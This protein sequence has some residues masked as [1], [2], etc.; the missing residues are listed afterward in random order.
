MALLD[1]LASTLPVDANAQ[2]GFT[3]GAQDYMTRRRAGLENQRLNREENFRKMEMNRAAPAYDINAFGDRIDTGLAT[4]PT[5][6]EEF[7]FTPIPGAGDMQPRL[8]PPD[9]TFNTGDTPTAGL[10]TSKTV[11]VPADQKGDASQNQIPMPEFVAPDLS[12]LFPQGT[13]QQTDTSDEDKVDL[14]VNGLPWKIIDKNGGKIVVHNGVEYNIKDVAGDGSSFQLVDT[15][16]RPNFALTD[17][18]TKGRAKGI[19]N[20]ELV[21]EDS[22]A[23]TQAGA[24]S[25]R[26]K[27]VNNAVTAIDNGRFRNLQSEMTVEQARL[28]GVP[29]GKALSLLAIE[30]NFGGVD[31]TKGP[32]KGALQ[33]EA[34]A[35]TDVKQFYAGKIPKGVDPAEWAKL[36]QAA[37]NLPKNFSQL[38]DNRDQITAGLLYFKLIGYKGVAPQFQAAAY[39]DGYGKFIGINSLQDVKKFAKNHDFKSVNTY[40]M[41]FLNLEDYL[42]K[43][44]NYFYPASGN[45]PP[46]PT[47]GP[48]PGTSTTTSTAN[49][50]SNTAVVDN[51]G[52]SMGVNPQGVTDSGGGLK[53]DGGGSTDKILKKPEDA[54]KLITKL[55]KNP[56]QL[57][58]EFS[59]ALKIRN[60]IAQR[61]ENMRRAGMTGIN[62][63]EYAKGIADIMVLDSS[64]YVMQAYDALNQFGNSGNP[65]RL[66]SVIDAFSGGTARI[67]ARTDGK[68]DFIRPDGSP[69]EGLTGLDKN[70]VEL[71]SRTM[72]D[73]KYRAS[74]EAAVT[75][76]NQ[77]IFESQLKQQEKQSELITK[78]KMDIMLERFKEAG[79]KTE[80]TAD[81]ARMVV[82]KDGQPVRSY[83]RELVEVEGPDG[84]K[85][86]LETFKL[87]TDI[88]QFNMGVGNAFLDEV[89]KIGR[90]Q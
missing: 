37:A 63:P 54:P 40:N 55:A 64:L 86:E 42:G 59:E 2:S 89:S 5:T 58:F 81:G 13:T 83:S 11:L 61:T 45:A 44:G 18:F 52:R 73:A 24:G 57:G 12:S 68:F 31:F 85:M 80:M 22:T 51:T 6:Q 17:A 23:E 71:N 20:T 15:Y 67:Q 14:H 28:L 74:I 39:N 53:K 76:K 87:D 38:S 69:I 75:A 4:P 84:N 48:A 8:G 36:K 33:I 9:G 10:D 34:P 72:F 46:V 77:A 65:D 3:Q 56:D 1:F 47:I 25:V 43:V 66:N 26:N 90:G 70:G 21:S 88:T 78:G 50:G 27:F 35:F 62:R 79:Y 41:A 30:S 7:T 60:V 49:T 19:V 82:T 16:G 32:A 29:E